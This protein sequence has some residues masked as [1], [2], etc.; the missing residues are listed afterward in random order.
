MRTWYFPRPEGG[1]ISFAMPDEATPLEIGG[2]A[3]AIDLEK[4][5]YQ[6]AARGWMPIPKHAFHMIQAQTLDGWR[7]AYWHPEDEAGR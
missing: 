3:L 2:D 6:H 1:T 5:T 4:M 7:P